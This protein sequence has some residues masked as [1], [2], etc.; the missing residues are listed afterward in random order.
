MRVWQAHSPSRIG[1]NRIA[2]ELRCTGQG[3]ETKWYYALGGESVGPVPADDI[4]ARI[5]GSSEPVLVWTAGMAEWADA[6]SLTAFGTPPD[7]VS[8][9]HAQGESADVQQ[10]RKA[11]LV[12]RARHEIIE[13]LAISGYLCICFS[14]ILFYKAAVLH[15]EGI[16]FSPYGFALVKALISAKFI[17]LLQ[18]LKLGERGLSDGGLVQK[19][20]AKALLF[21]IFLLVLTVIEEIVVGHFHHRSV[22]V[23]LIGLTS[24]RGLEVIASSILLFL[25]MIPYFAYREVAPSLWPEDKV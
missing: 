2:H 7:G 15:S 4:R 19:I 3:M 9:A 6:R 10:S 20:F 11:R 21:T 23:V 16:E 18:G 13:Y 1:A 17:M 8:D 14:A 25:I 12:E 24:G 5:G 22:S